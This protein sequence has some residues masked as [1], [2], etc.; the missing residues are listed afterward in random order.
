MTKNQRKHLRFELP[1]NVKVTTGNGNELILKSHDISDSGI[2][3]CGDLAV[4][5]IVGEVVVIKLASMVA[6]DEP[7]ELNAVVVRQSD[8]GIGIEFLLDD[9]E[10][11]E[12]D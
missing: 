2:F 9:E 7:R 1:V 4:L 6:G 10:L 5:P 12:S 3:L 8:A 11:V